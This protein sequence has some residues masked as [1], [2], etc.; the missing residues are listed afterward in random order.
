MKVGKGTI[1]Y[2]P[3]EIVE[4]KNH[5][6]VIG[7]NCRIGQFSFIAARNFIM[8]EGAEISPLVV[9]GG[10]GDVVLGKFSTINFGAKLIP[11]TFSTKGQYMNDLHEKS[12]FIRG[13]IT[14]G[15]GAYIGSGAIIC[16]S[17]EHPHI[18]IGDFA[19][20]GALSYIDKDV[21][22]NMIVHPK[23]TM[24]HVERRIIHDL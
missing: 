1:I 8:N 5:H 13:S 20:I 19:V 2:K 18:K 12:K 17:E 3:V 21:P 6:I 23:Q 15:E 16:I 7:K 11:A 24:Y 9:I 14:I 10:G 4:T 22:E